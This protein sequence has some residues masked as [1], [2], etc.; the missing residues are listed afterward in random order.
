MKFRTEIKPHSPSFLIRSQDR[1]LTSGSCFTVHIG[2]F[3]KDHF[4]NIKVNPFGTLFNP[5]S[6]W[7]LIKRVKDGRVF[8]EKDIFF[9]DGQWKSFDLYSHFNRETK[10]DF[11]HDINLLLQE[12]HDF[13]TATDLLIITYGTAQVFIE[14]Q[15][16]QIVANCHKIPAKHFEKRMLSASEI[17]DYTEKIY[18]ASKAMNPSMKFIFSVSPVRYLQDGMLAN[19]QSK[20]RLLDALIDFTN[21]HPSDTYYFPAFEIFSDDLRDYRFYASDLIHPG[22]QGIRYT[23]EIFTDL[24]FDKNGKQMLRET[25]KLRKMMQHRFF[26]ENSEETLKFQEKTRNKINELKQKFPGLL[27]PE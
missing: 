9:H 15:S 20:A 14:K 6:I 1:I 3:L 23:T 4:F 10:K 21:R 27:F 11:L 2:N 18:R 25:E 19:S 24:F 17:D 12:V 26:D 16:G 13:L 7:Q 5:H 8:E 22:E